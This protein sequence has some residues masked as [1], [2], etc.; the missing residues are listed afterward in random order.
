[1]AAPPPTWPIQRTTLVSRIQ[2]SRFNWTRRKQNG[3]DGIRKSE[4]TTLSVIAATFRNFNQAQFR[5]VTLGAGVTE[6]W[7]RIVGH[8]YFLYVPAQVIL[9][10]DVLQRPE[11]R[12]NAFRTCNTPYIGGR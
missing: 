1:M 6:E 12:Q 2:F 9:S 10:H 7:A 8:P 4:S 3:E 11:F 5:L